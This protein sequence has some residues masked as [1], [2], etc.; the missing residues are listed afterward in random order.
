M[1]L[2]LPIG[3]QKEVLYLQARG[4]FVVLG[5]AGSGKTILAILRS[6]YLADP[7]TDHHGKVLLV[8]FNRALVA[9]LRHLQ[10]RKLRNVVVENYHTF[11]RGYL[12]S[13]DK[14]PFRGILSPDDR[15]LLVAKAVCEVSNSYKPHPFFERPV[16][17]FSEEFRWIAQHG[18][19]TLAVY[20]DADRIGKAS[21]R[22]DHK[23]RNV[24][25]EIY[26][27]Y[28]ALREK[29]GKSY[30]WDD[31]AV[32]V[33]TEFD[34]D[35]TPRRYR[36]VVIDEGQDFSPEMLR[37]LAKAIPPDGS[38]T[39]FGDVAQQIYGHRMSWRSAGLKITKI[40]EFKENYRNSRQIARLGLAISQMPYFLDVPD[41]V[42]P[43]SPTADGPL[44]TLVACSSIDKEIEL[45]VSQASMG[46]RTLRVA[47]LLRNRQEEEHLR[48][49]LPLGSI[50]LHRNMQTWHAGP[51]LWYGTYHSAK[52]LE[53]DMVILPFCSCERLPDPEAVA[54]FGDEDAM[55]QDGRL[56][57]VAVTRAKTRLVITYSGQIS[58][59]L[60]PDAGLYNKVQ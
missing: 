29:S 34:N 60:P 57:Y 39:F 7:R 48:S 2:P 43:V 14:M 11:A 5:T 19:T 41:I 42:E 23:F 13:R 35:A 54:A 15:K 27:A 51:G 17:V 49:R 9:Y 46:S 28:R 55:I 52:G 4:H 3:R 10:D 21:V 32:A 50:R 25:W 18:I 20:R 36:H 1:G 33:C 40:W 58:P 31:L 44:P 16:D 53:F 26:E 38:L 30:D 56:L 45:A 6:A 24:V 37:S 12:A 8:T 47:L 22:I 59:L